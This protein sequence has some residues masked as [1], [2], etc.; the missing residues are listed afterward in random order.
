MDLRLYPMDTQKCKLEI[1]S[2]KH[3]WIKYLEKR[4]TVKK[5]STFDYFYWANIVGKQTKK[6]FRCVKKKK[7]EKLFSQTVKF[8]IEKFD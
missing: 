5:N 8:L 1:E 7:A 2:C 3:F 6:L 4:S